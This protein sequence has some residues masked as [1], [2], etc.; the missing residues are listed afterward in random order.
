MKLLL[1]WDIDG[2]LTS[3]GG[4]G[5]RA[6]QKGLRNEFGI[7]GL[8]D[9]IEFAGRTDPWI[10]R[11]IFEKFA[12]PASEENFRRLTDAYLREL[13]GALAEGPARVLPGVRDV[14]LAAAK[15]PGVAQGLLTGN[16]R[17]GAQV[18][19]E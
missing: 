13:P 18:K 12:L 5:M 16:L 14:L 3:S 10:M 11:R 1:F 17:R 7:K 9:D 8:L 2:T 6:L 19:L 4:A 15:R